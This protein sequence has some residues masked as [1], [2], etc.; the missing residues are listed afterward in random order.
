MLCIEHKR[1]VL[2]CAITQLQPIFYCAAQVH[3]SHGEPRCPQLLQ[4]APQRRR[5]GEHS[6]KERQ[7][8]LGT[9]VCCWLKW[10]KGMVVEFSNVSRLQVINTSTSRGAVCTAAVWQQL[11]S[12]LLSTDLAWTYLTQDTSYCWLMAFTGNPESRKTLG[13]LWFILFPHHFPQA[14]SHI[15][16]S[17][18]LALQGKWEKATFR[19]MKSLSLLNKYPLRP[20]KTIFEILIRKS[21]NIWVERDPLG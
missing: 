3:T 16:W 18:T 21:E 9:S 4:L 15:I 14:G 12:A 20:T 8:W 11:R 5:A 10:G 13:L 2:R 17:K 7:R 6:S 19:S 1:C